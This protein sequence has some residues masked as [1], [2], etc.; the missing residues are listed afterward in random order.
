MKNISH[1]ISSENEL[2]DKNLYISK[3]TY[4]RNMCLH[5]HDFY[6]IQIILDGT[7]NQSI[8]GVKYT[9]HKG[10]LYFLNPYDIHEY[11]SESPVTIIKIQFD[12]SILDKSLS[13]KI[14]A[15]GNS[16]ILS[17]DDEKLENCLSIV[18]KLLF[19]FENDL[20]DRDQMMSFL[21]NCLMIQI[22]RLTETRLECNPSQPIMSAL[23]YIHK[24]FFKSPS[25]K[26]VA[27]QTFLSVN[28]FCYLFKREVGIPY[29]QYLR[30]LQIKKAKTLL[31]STDN[32][33]MQICN[34]CGY[35]SFSHF[36]TDFKENVGVTPNDYRKM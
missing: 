17:L 27:N 20:T 6:E 19:E 25:L 35:S 32:T 16:I 1:L 15:D 5:W 8:N 4:V 33:I 28:Y 34:E 29:K 2:K 21:M 30:K 7:L 12:L 14:S 22:M 10:Y 18:N 26:E 11:S 9:M 13:Q 23:Q 36:M 3:K 24:N 31:K